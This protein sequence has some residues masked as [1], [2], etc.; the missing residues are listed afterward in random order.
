MDKN[1]N[2][3]ALSFEINYLQRILKNILIN[4]VHLKKE[5]L[6]TRITNYKN[7]SIIFIETK[8]PL[9]E[10]YIKLIKSENKNEI[11]IARIIIANNKNGI[12]TE[13][14]KRICKFGKKYNYKIITFDSPNLECEKFMKK[15]GFNPDISWS[16]KIK[17]LRKS[18]RIY[19]K[20]N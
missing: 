8:K 17:K 10:L 15:I 2:T 20:N 11:I 6:F 4:K 3:R 13:L 12:G 14:L 9:N 7:H 18:I 19:K 16:I 1:I 5:K